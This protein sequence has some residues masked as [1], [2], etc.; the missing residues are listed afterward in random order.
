MEEIKPLM[1]RLPSFFVIGAQKAGTTT[2][3]DWLIQQPD[4]CLPSIKETHFFNLDERYHQGIDWYLQQFPECE[5]GAVVGEICPAY[6]FFEV[7]PLRIK[8]DIDSPKFIIIFRDPIDRAY[9]HYL[10][11]FGRGHETLSFVEA[12][13]AEEKRLSA[14]DNRF[15]LFHHSYIARGKYCEQVKR[16]KRIFPA[17]EFLYIKFNDLF[18]EKEGFESYKKI[19]SFIDIKS[20]PEIADRNKKSNQASTSRSLLL[21]NFLYKSSWRSVRRAM[22]GMFG[23]SIKI[24]IRRGIEKLNQSP[25]NKDNLRKPVDIPEPILNTLRNEILELQDMTGLDLHE[26]IR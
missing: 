1:K 13:L 5:D 21:R 16:Y 14:D 10:M 24:K 8:K 11:S 12:L 17:S 23:D 6:L 9:S 22:G 25:V 20:E 18:S 26:W 7:V 15:A 3:H 2:L 4:V 19:C